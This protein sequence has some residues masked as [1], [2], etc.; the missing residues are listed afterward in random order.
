MAQ[1]PTSQEALVATAATNSETINYIQLLR[2]IK[3]NNILLL[4]KSVY[5]S[6]NHASQNIVEKIPI[7]GE[8]TVTTFEIFDRPFC[9][10]QLLCH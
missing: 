9:L 8:D 4:S 6:I 5:N 10:G 3:L 2:P 7:F 1:A